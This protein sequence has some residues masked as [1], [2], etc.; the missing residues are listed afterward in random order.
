MIR[1]Q[2][3]IEVPLV[4]RIYQIIKYNGW[5]D[6]HRN[7]NLKWIVS[8]FHIMLQP[9]QCLKDNALSLKAHFTLLYQALAHF[10]DCTIQALTS[11]SLCT[12]THIRRAA[13]KKIVRRM[14]AC[15]HCIYSY[16]VVRNSYLKQK[17]IMSYI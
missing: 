6:C 10:V 4:S 12:Y 5:K 3:E 2:T 16:V 13:S 1:C 14:S 15:D 11:L 7:T 17:K 8:K 9:T